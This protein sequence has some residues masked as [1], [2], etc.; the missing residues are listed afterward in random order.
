VSS[1]KLMMR[2]TLS[3]LSTLVIGVTS[4]AES[5][6]IIPAEYCMP[7]LTTHW[8]ALKG[9]DNLPVQVRSR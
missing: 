1:T 4:I 6:S 7:H 5:L 2:N 9:T 3:R 8:C